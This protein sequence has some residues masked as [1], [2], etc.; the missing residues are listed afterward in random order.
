MDFFA[1]I[2]S[3]LREVR[4]ARKL[5][6]SEVADIAAR[7]GVAGSTRQAVALYEKAERMPSAPYL[8]A[9]AADG[10]DIAYVLT[11][12]PLP[13]NLRDHFQRA[14]QATLGADAGDESLSEAYVD[15]VARATRETLDVELLADILAAVGLALEQK[16]VTLAPEKHA[17]LVALL[18]EHESTRDADSRTELGD[19]T[20]RY[21]KL[22]A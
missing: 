18:Y 3:R 1:S 16:R 11:G 15:S 22:V 8:T 10:F 5:S 13:G 7:A 14:A 12:W 19:I 17:R 9:L 20:Q 2:G 6:Q 21:L 4:E